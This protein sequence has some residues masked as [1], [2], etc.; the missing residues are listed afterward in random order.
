M[1]LMYRNKLYL[2]ERKIHF[3]VLFAF[4][5][6]VKCLILMSFNNYWTF[7]KVS[8]LIAKIL[9][10][11]NVC[12]CKQLVIFTEKSAFIFLIADLIFDSSILKIFNLY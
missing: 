4:L 10:P 11:K 8:N 9:A 6:N 3:K 1:F 2:V 12:L 7:F 5:K